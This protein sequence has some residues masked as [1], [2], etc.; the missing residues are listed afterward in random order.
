MII[1][2]QQLLPPNPH[3]PPQLVA[4][5]SPIR[6]SSKLSLHS[7]NMQRSNLCDSKYYLI[8]EAGMVLNLQDLNGLSV[9]IGEDRLHRKW[10]PHL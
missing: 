10:K 6:N 7:Y 5:K 1:Q 3:P 4:D 9:D 2:V 8:C